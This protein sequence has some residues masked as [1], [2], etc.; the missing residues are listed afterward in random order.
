MIEH[1]DVIPIAVVVAVAIFIARECLDAVRRYRARARKLH[2]IRCLVA[3][4]C[5]RNNFALSR[6]SSQVGRT[7]AARGIG[8]EIKIEPYR[9]GIPR[10]SFERHGEL[11]TSSPLFPIQTTQL[12][13]FLFDAAELDAGLFELMEKAL[14][15]L[16]AVKHVRD[17]LIDYVSN[18]PARLEGFSEYATKELDKALDPLRDVYFKCSGEPLT[19]A[20]VR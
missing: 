20:R 7:E 16:I 14:D 3:A 1:P 18:D 5:E 15:A 4:E 11:S 9:N 2:A 17:S 6:L 19:E 8:E 13:R 12:E 10:L